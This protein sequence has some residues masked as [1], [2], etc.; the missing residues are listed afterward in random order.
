MSVCVWISLKNILRSFACGERMDKNYNTT[1][2]WNKNI[3]QSRILDLLDFPNCDVLS[4]ADIARTKPY[5][6]V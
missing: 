3:R 5:L 6:R 4:N 1:N 2:S